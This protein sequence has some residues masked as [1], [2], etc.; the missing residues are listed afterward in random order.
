MPVLQRLMDGPDRYSDVHYGG[1]RDKSTLRLMKII[2]EK[3]TQRTFSGVPWF[4]FY[5]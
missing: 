1:Y 3:P 4:M 5:A 2:A